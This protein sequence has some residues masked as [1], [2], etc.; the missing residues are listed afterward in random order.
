MPSKKC[1]SLWIVVFVA[2]GFI[3][4]FKI[5]T[6]R[7]NLTK[8][9]TS[10]CMDAFGKFLKKHFFPLLHFKELPPLENGD[11][12]AEGGI[13]GSKLP[14]NYSAVC[15]IASTASSVQLSH[16]KRTQLKATAVQ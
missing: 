2:L 16:L 12:F 8:Q 3:L 1:L 9:V 4:C 11:I 14:D 15:C 6:H 7:L 10:P 13:F 5:Q